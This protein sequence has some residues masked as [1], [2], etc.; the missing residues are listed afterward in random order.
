MR[1]R[2]IALVVLFAAVAAFPQQQRPSIEGV[3]PGLQ[4]PAHFAQKIEAGK[5]HVGS[6]V[7]ARLEIA[8]LING[9]VV[10][11]D[12]VLEGHVEES[13]ARTPDGPSRLRVVMDSAHWKGGQTHFIAYLTNRY[14]PFVLH[15]RDDTATSPEDELPQASAPR[16]NR[17]QQN[18]MAR[19]RGSMDVRPA[20]QRKATQDT[21]AG[22]SPNRVPIANVRPVSTP[23]GAVTLTSDRNIKLDKRTVYGFDGGASVAAQKH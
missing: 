10:P 1:I 18:A 11:R 15:D 8:T 9:Q 13:V 5:T 6:A 20:D 22:I 7:R 21:L 12:A 16:R 19:A 3:A 14:H 4:L 2:V 23:T 17:R